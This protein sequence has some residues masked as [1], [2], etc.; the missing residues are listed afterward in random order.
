[1]FL[2]NNYKQ[3][4]AI[5]GTESRLREGMKELNVLNLSEFDVWMEEER[6]YLGTL[7][8]EL[9]EETLL[10]EYYSKLVILNSCEYVC[11]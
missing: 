11:S 7:S 1:M 6:E 3:A 4:L 9:M 8:K 5:I 2:C 10:M